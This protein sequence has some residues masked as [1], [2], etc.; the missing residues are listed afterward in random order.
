METPLNEFPALYR[1]DSAAMEGTV[2]Y[3]PSFAELRYGA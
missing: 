3:G 1:R 2:E